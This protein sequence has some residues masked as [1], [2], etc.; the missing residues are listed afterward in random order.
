MDSHPRLVCPPVLS[1][2]VPAPH[3]VETLET[4]T[5][6][7]RGEA[8]CQQRDQV[9]TEIATPGHPLVIVTATVAVR[10]IQLPA[11]KGALEPPEQRRMTDVH[12]EGDLRLAAVAPEVPL[13]DE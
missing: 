1:G 4:G 11:R 8:S 3:G 9:L 12:A 13:A 7:L 10:P 6:D 5:V 2:N